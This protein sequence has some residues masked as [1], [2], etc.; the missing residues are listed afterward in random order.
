MK[1]ADCFVL[2]VALLGAVRWLV[3]A[4]YDTDTPLW[5]TGNVRSCLALC[6]LERP[7]HV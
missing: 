2:I 6:Y 1:H 7:R 5:C 4:V 3:D